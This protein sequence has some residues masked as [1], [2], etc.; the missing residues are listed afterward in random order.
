MKSKFFQQ[1]RQCKIHKE[2]GS[3]NGWPRDIGAKVKARTQAKLDRSLLDTKLATE[4]T[5]FSG[6]A[7]AD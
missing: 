5:G 2:G 6:N 7:N 1:G 4:N 3:K